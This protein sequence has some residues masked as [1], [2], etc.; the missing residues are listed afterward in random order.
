MSMPFQL[1]KTLRYPISRDGN[2]G[3][4]DAMGQNSQQSRHIDDVLNVQRA[5]MAVVTFGHRG[6]RK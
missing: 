6:K 1:H 2:N 5:L 3:I 4:C